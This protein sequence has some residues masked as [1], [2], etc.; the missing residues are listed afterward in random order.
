VVV[1]PAVIRS[2]LADPAGRSTQ[3]ALGGRA[4]WDGQRTGAVAE[5]ANPEEPEDD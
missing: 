5:T 4:A 2:A 1:D 3:S